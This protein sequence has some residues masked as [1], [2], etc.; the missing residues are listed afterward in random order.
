[1][2]KD[3]RAALRRAVDAYDQLVS[4]GRALTS[5]G[6]QCRSEVLG[7]MRQLTGANSDK[8]ALK[9]ARKVLLGGF[10]SRQPRAKGLSDIVPRRATPNAFDAIRVT[11]VVPTAVET[12][13]GKH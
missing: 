8:S 4:D 12:N 2:R 13:R 10:K 6:I 9:R 5:H 1:M 3:D 7:T 11:Q